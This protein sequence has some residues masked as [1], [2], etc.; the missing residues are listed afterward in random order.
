MRSVQ[1]LSPMLVMANISL[2]FCSA[3]EALK[4][5]ICFHRKKKNN[6][7]QNHT[8][9][10]SFH[11]GLQIW[12]L[13]AVQSRRPNSWPRGSCLVCVV[14]PPPSSMTAFL[15]TV[16]GRNLFFLNLFKGVLH[17][18]ALLCLYSMNLALLAKVG[19]NE[20]N[21]GS[22]QLWSRSAQTVCNT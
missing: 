17:T 10:S 18:S 22:M 9:L 11:I 19:A 7:I 20:S 15:S 1:E 3:S 21:I 16:G 2:C 13:W 14:Q 6:N 12:C 5:I 8:K 4:S